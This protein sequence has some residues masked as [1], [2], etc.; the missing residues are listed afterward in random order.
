MAA[1][2]TVELEILALVKDATSTVAK[3]ARDTQK[4]LSGISFNTTI[5]AIN[6]GFELVGKTVGP[7]INGIKDGLKDVVAESAAAEQ[8][9]TGLANALRL[10]GDF[11]EGAVRNFQDLATQ[12]QATTVFSDEQVLSAAALGKQF[13]LT[14]QETESAI[15]VAADLAAVTGQDLNSAMFSV[16]QSFNGFVDKGLAKAIPGLKNLSKE[17]LISGQGLELIRARVDGSAEALSNTF[18]GAL[19]K[20]GNALSDVKETLGGFITDNPQVIAIILEVKKAFEQVNSAIAQNGDSIR[21]FIKDGIVLLIQAVPLAIQGVQ[22]LIT[23]FGSLGLAAAKTGKVL[24]AVAAGIST[25]FQGTQGAGQTILAALDEDLDNLNTSFGAFLNNV[26]EGFAPVIKA[27]QDLADRVKTVQGSVKTLGNTTKSSLSGVKERFKE[28]FDPDQLAA[29]NTQVREAQEKIKESARTAIE[30]ATKNPVEGTIKFLVSGQNQ[31]TKTTA[32]IDAAVKAIVASKDIPEALKKQAVDFAKAA[33]DSLQKQFSV[34]QGLGIVNT[35][36]KGAEGAKSLV[37]GA[38]GAAA[39]ALLPGIGGV[40]SEIAGALAEGP[41]K[42]KE[43][44]RSFVQA[45][46]DIIVNIVKAIPALIQAL[47]EQIPILVERLIAA[48]PQIVEALAKSMPLVGLRLALEAPKIAISF[49]QALVRN[50]PQIVAGFVS[51]LFEAAGRFIDALVQAVTDA[52]NAVGNGLT[53][54]GQSDSVF[55]GIPVLQGIGDLFGFAEG[56]RIPDLP[57][58]AGDK[59]PAKLSA[60]EQIFSRDLTNRL[61]QFLT[62]QGGGAPSQVVI[63]I[64]EK[65]MARVLLDLNRNGFRTS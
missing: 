57:Q 27:A 62:G 25:L 22:G 56:G 37:T 11:S 35:I 55:A 45:L 13:R 38:I 5:S 49:I 1:R 19:A 36:L 39:D 44:V 53:G 41:E 3:F 28:I 46:P 48:L 64:G 31:L 26:D 60:G 34:G 61:E 2:T 30:G 9:I 33:K 47:V 18:T 15:R 58:Y 40:V 29:F 7:V 51:G 6:D 24:G 42:V 20:A 14:N 65:E 59:F 10:S 4:S 12:I 16:A 8:A 17:A 21:G 63:K 32:E 43:M 23:T 54:S 52:F 50:I